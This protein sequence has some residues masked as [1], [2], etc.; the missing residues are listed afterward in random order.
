M[1]V[2]TSKAVHDYTGH[3]PARVIPSP[4]W[5]IGSF[6][7]HNRFRPWSKQ[8]ARARMATIEALH[9]NE[10]LYPPVNIPLKAKYLA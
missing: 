8:N 1:S 3:K 7:D 6:I 9:D 5:Y 10:I 4:L 2:K